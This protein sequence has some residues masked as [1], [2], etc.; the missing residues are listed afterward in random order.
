MIRPIWFALLLAPLTACDSGPRNV[1]VPVAPPQVELD[2]SASPPEARVGEPVKLHVVR[3]YRGAWKQ[4]ARQSLKE[5]QCWLQHPPP[6][7]EKEV[8]DNVQWIPFPPE[9]VSFNSGFRR[10]HVREA[11]FSRP[12]VYVLQPRSSVWCGS[13]NPTIG[14]SLKVVVRESRQR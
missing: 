5:G 11:I 8:A 6:A 10:D 12:G 4:V 9:G 14:P 1:Y 7:A 3:H 2:V 13:G